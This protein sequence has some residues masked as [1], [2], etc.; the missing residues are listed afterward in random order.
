MTATRLHRFYEDFISPEMLQLGTDKY[1]DDDQ[2]AS[3]DPL[4]DLHVLLSNPT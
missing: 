3:K 2:V 4:T 1:Y